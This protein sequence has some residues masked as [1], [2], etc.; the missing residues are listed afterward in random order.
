M[1]AAKTIAFTAMTLGVTMGSSGSNHG[2]AQTWT[3]GNNFPHGGATGTNGYPSEPNHV[4][5]DPNP[6]RQPGFENPPGPHPGSGPWAPVS[7]ASEYH[8]DYKRVSDAFRNLH[9]PIGGDVAG[10][11][12]FIDYMSHL[13]SMT[14]NTDRKYKGKL[15]IAHGYA[16]HAAAGTHNNQDVTMYVEVVNLP[17]DGVVGCEPLES[18]YTEVRESLS[19]QLSYAIDMFED[20]TGDQEEIE[21]LRTDIENSQKDVHAIQVFC[22]DLANMLRI[23]RNVYHAYTSAWG[24]IKFGDGTLAK[25]RLRAT[26]ESDITHREVV[27]RALKN[28]DHEPE[29]RVAL[30][31]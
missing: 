22:G 3:E 6:T 4:T 5:G 29:V 23:R 24:Q 19:N 7:R 14:S 16:Q 12:G 9:F 25:R 28:I 13:E 1:H 21:G 30:L 18:F 20:N 15:E 2:T 26:E 10:T 11:G 27:K 31:M 17:A 8:S